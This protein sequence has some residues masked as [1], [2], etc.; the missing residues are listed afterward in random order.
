[1]EQSHE[2]HAAIYERSL[3]YYFK[4]EFASAELISPIMNELIVAGQK[5]TPAAYEEALAR[6]V[7]LARRMDAFFADYDVLVT[8]STAGEGPPRS[9]VE[10]PDSALMWTLAHLSVVSAPAFVSPHGKPF[11][12]QLVA[13]RYNDTLLFRF[14]EELVGK[15]LLP[16]GCNPPVQV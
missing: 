1:M 16:P 9:E 4:D 13:R 5:I 15:A 10:A 3:A 11:G 12:L 2:V 7:T 6:Q 8:L 14:V